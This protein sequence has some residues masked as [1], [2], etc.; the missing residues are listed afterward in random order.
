MWC[1]IP[2]GERNAKGGF[3]FSHYILYS[4]YCEMPTSAVKFYSCYQNGFT[5]GLVKA[6][7]KYLKGK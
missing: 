4:P 6:G 7:R 5:A 2:Y 3:S 1:I